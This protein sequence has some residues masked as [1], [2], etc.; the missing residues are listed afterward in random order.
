[1]RT[2]D[3]N[4]LARNRKEQYQANKAVRQ[5]GCPGGWLDDFETPSKLSRSDAVAN[6]EPLQYGND[7]TPADSEGFHSNLNLPA[8]IKKTM[9]SQSQTDCLY[10]PE[11]MS[12]RSSQP[13][14][15]CLHMTRASCRALQRDR[16]T[17]PP[18]PP[19]RL[20]HPPQ[21][22]SAPDTA[23]SEGEVRY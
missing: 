6:V 9:S 8:K 11:L 14:M 19:L 13:I 20:C 2:R 3:T 17:Q 4:R 18:S 21:P 16:A 1:M 5:L 22:P 23:H 7:S 15:R 12:N 10:S